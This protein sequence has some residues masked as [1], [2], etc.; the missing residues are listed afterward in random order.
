MS[1]ASWGRSLLKTA[2][3][4]SKRACCCRKFRAAG[5]VASFFSVRCM[6]SWRPVGQ[7]LHPAFLVAIEDFIAGLTRDPKLPAQV[8]DWLAGEPQTE[9]FRPSPNT[10]S[11]ASLPPQKG[12]TVFHVS[13][14]ICYLCVGSVTQL[15]VSVL[16]A[17]LFC[18]RPPHR[19]RYL[20]SALPPLALRR[21]L[22]P[23]QL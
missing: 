9:A 7:P 1:R 23:L 22:S 20:S 13:G 10:P 4:L 12:E 19:S 21:L 8:R 3:K 5:W 16:Y 2:M 14:T 17:G 15:L 18:S 6:R 11:T